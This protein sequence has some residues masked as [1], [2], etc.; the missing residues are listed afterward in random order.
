[1]NNKRKQYSAAFKAKI[2]L[3]ALNGHHTINELA[4]LYELHSSQISKWKGELTKGADVIFADKRK[5]E[6]E[7]REKETEELY[8]QIGK[9]KVEI[10]WLK[11][12]SGLLFS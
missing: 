6:N 5:K 3:A 7:T 4:T 10:D 2:A 8:K 11:K 9:Q 1:M 12:K